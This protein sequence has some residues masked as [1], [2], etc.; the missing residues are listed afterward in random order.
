MSSGREDTQQKGSGRVTTI[1][2]RAQ[3]KT[4]GIKINT[5]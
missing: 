1:A 3:L 4:T 5:A 2:L